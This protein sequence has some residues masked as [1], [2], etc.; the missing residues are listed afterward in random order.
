MSYFATS[1]LVDVR[2]GLGDIRCVEDLAALAHL[3]LAVDQLPTAFHALEGRGPLLVLAIGTQ[4]LGLLV[5]GPQ[6]HALV[7]ALH[8]APLPA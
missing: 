7:G 5:A 1:S 4:A 3:P 8:R 2:R 6:V